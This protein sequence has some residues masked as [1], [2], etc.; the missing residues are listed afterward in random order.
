MFRAAEVS[1]TSANTAAGRK[2][3]SCSS[4]VPRR[5]TV[6]AFWDGTDASGKALKT[7]GNESYVRHDGLYPDNAIFV[8]NGLQLSD[9]TAT[10]TTSR[11]PAISSAPRTRL[12]D[13][14]RCRSSRRCRCGVPSGTNALLRTVTKPAGAPSGV[15]E[16]MGADNGPRRLR[17][18]PPALKAFDAAG[19]Q[20]LVRYVVVRVYYCGSR[21]AQAHPGGLLRF[22]RD[23]GGRRGPF[24]RTILAATKGVTR[25]CV[26]GLQNG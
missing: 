5:N 2:L 6:S 7:I 16:W 20:S 1:I 19:N 21:N 13:Q 11:A 26:D 24:G 4:A 12:R 3:S 8:E 9:V 14:L 23:R 25:A 18:L 22:A 15:I 10:L 17:G